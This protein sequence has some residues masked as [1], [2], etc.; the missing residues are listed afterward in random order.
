MTALANA[1]WTV[2]RGTY[3]TEPIPAAQISGTQPVSGS[4]TANWGTITTGTTYN[5]VTAASTN[6]AVIKATAGS[7]YE[8][9]ISNTTA[10][11]AYVKLYNKT[12]A[13]TVG[14]DVPVLT[15]PVAASAA[16]A[17]TV[18][19]S[20]GTV[21]KRFATG[22]GIAVTA[23]PLATDTAVAVA[24]IQVNATYI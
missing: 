9:T 18:I 15:I 21:G 6:A 17:G 16:G 13:P 11:P 10:T 24:G 20:F 3:A 2:L 4:V 23:G 1:S 12:T 14:T 8:I 7:M 5:V 22:I 19:T